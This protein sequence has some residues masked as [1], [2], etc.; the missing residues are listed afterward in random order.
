M[1][2]FTVKPKMSSVHSSL[3]CIGITAANGPFSAQKRDI[4]M[5]LIFQCFLN[6]LN[7]ILVCILSFRQI[8]FIFIIIKVAFEFLY[9]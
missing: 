2:S 8:I 6:F 5:P 9:Y 3:R 4:K 7:N 1:N